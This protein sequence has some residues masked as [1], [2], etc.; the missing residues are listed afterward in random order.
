MSSTTPVKGDLGD[1]L[2]RELHVCREKLAECE[3]QLKEKDDVLAVSLVLII[4]PED[5][6]ANLDKN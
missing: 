5:F 1:E 4:H 2:S 3:Q 6:G